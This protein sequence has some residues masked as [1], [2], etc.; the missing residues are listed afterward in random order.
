MNVAAADMDGGGRCAWERA[1]AAYLDGELD[2]DASGAFESHAK[3]C[4]PCAAALREQRRLLCLL[5]NAFDETFERK[6]ALP[7]DFTR[8]VKARAQTDMSGVRA[9]R[10]RTISLKICV[11]LACAIFALL[12][13]PSLDALAGTTPFYVLLFALAYTRIPTTVLEA[14]ELEGMSPYAVWRRVALPLARPAVVAVATLSFVYYWS[15]FMDPLTLVASPRHWPV[16]LGLRNLAEMEAALYPIYLAGA[17][18]ATA[19]AVLAFLVG[20]RS[21]FASVEQR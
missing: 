13:A 5:D 10:E 14:A 2:A 21:F 6:V 1:T 18:I 12:G 15:T 20:Q 16:S 4:A 7:P 17:V 19:P 3:E 11:G 8:V 9:P